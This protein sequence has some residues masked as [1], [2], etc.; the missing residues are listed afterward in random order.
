MKEIVTEQDWNDVFEASAEKK[1]FVLKH[2]TTCPISA[3]AHAEYLKYVEETSASDSLYSYVKVIESRPISNLI[4][5]QLQVK[6]ESPQL[7][8]LKDKQ[9]QW[10]KSHWNITKKNIEQA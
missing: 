2:S 4:A 5:E 3:E 6:H 10:A 8:I 1:V 7:I 9:V